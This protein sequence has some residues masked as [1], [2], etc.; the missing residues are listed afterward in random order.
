MNILSELGLLFKGQRKARGYTQGEVAELIGVT[1]QTVNS[2]ENGEH[3]SKRCAAW[4]ETEKEGR[5]YAR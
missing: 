4:L 5:K 2:F 3:Y 1:R